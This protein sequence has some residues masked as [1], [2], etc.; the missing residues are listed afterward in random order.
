[1]PAIVFTAQWLKSLKPPTDKDREPWFDSSRLG[2][3]QSLLLM[4]HRSGRKVWWAYYGKNKKI[5]LGEYPKMGLKD[6]DEAAQR[7]LTLLLDNIDPAQVRREQAGLPTFEYVAEYFLLR[8]ASTL[9]DSGRRYRE[10]I[11]REFI[12]VW[13]HRKAQELQRRDVV[14]VLEAIAERGHRAANM[15]HAVLRK[16]FNWAIRRDL[17]EHNPV[18]NIDRPGGVEQSR[19]RVLSQDEIRALWSGLDKAA[20][21]DEIKL[22][23]RLILATGQR[24][25][26]LRKAGKGEFDLVNN[27]WTIPAGH[28]KNGQS[29]RVP[30][31][32]LAAGLVKRAF[33][34]HPD[35]ALLFPSP[36]GGAVMAETAIDRAVRN[37]REVFGIDHWTPHDLRR[38]AA[39]LC[40]GMGVDRLVIKKI[41]NHTDS[42]ITAVYDR[43]GYDKEKQQ[44]LN[45]W[46][47]ELQTITRG[48]AA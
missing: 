22:L 38:T 46:G 18:T 31:S 26:E 20:M 45:K 33:K 12:P 41:L 37:N 34:L 11:E 15:A 47:R 27:W 25:G 14:P 16:L 3:G 35:S 13:R 39:S 48:A 40:A 32:P 5:R 36:R 19:D 4:N 28:A 10:I 43:H 17:M 7:E 2:K 6:A 30:L 21:A 23:L 9:A 24:K 42:D 29:H 8:H 1:M 44:A